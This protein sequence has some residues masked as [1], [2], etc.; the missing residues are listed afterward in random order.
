M[1]NKVFLFI[2]I[3][4]IIFAILTILNSIGKENLENISDEDKIK[5]MKVLKIENSST[6]LPIEIKKGISGFGDTNL[7]YTLKFEISITDYNENNLNYKNKDTTEISLN[8]KEQ[9]YENTYTCY[10]REWEYNNHRKELF[11]ELKKLN[12]KY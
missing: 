6:F 7:K 4:V 2:G 12:I 3:I 10:V 5:L 9:K 8:W 1:K 11:N